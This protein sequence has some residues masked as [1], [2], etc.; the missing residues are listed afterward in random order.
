[1]HQPLL[2]PYKALS[3]VIPQ[4]QAVVARETTQLE[5]LQRP[6]R[7][8]KHCS[9]TH[10]HSFGV[11]CLLGEAFDRVKRVGARKRTKSDQAF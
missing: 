5:Q 10:F 2:H 3:H 4:V 11:L 6:V 7:H 9:R 8:M 1:M